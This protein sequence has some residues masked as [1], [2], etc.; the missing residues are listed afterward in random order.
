M[1]PGRKGEELGYREDEK[2]IEGKK[3]GGEM[4]YISWRK[5]GG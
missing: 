3:R 4:V 2:V 1:L 5:G